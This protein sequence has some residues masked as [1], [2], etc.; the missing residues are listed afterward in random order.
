MTEGRGEI[1][2]R[3]TLKQGNEDASS[4]EAVHIFPVSRWKIYL[5]CF[6]FCYFFPFVSI[7]CDYF[8]PL[9]L[10]TAPEEVAVLQEPFAIVTRAI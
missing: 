9:G 1:K 4:S 7:R 3:Y 5:I 6:L 10:A 2:I 8:W